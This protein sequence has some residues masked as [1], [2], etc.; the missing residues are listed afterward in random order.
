MLDTINDK[1]PHHAQYCAFREILTILLGIY[2]PIHKILKYTF[3]SKEC[4]VNKIIDFYVT[5]KITKY[6]IDAE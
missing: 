2:K 4:K 1:Y 5:H 6:R 3:F